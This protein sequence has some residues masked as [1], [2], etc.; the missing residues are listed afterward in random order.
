M[1]VVALYA[2]EDS[3]DASEL[4]GYIGRTYHD[5]EMDITKKEEKV[6]KLKVIA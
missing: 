4:F 3:L 1:L 5:Q 2:E 6:G